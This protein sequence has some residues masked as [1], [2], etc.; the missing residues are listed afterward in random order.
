VYN[1]KRSGT[2]EF[3]GGRFLLHKK[4]FPEKPSAEWYIVD[5]LCSYEMMDASLSKLAKNLVGQLRER[6]WDVNRLREIAKTY[7]NRAT[8]ALVEKCITEAQAESSTI[9]AGV[10]RH[11]AR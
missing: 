2:F 11:R 6:R 1:T 7:G 9:V 8:A 4:A 5:L 10:R 3:G